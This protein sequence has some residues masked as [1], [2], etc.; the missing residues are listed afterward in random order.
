VIQADVM[1]TNGVVH[2]LGRVIPA[3]AS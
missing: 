2:V 1:A 3:P